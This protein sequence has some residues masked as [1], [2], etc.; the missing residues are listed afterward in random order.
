MHCS[1]HQVGLDQG[2]LSDARN[3][4]MSTSH[5]FLC[6]AGLQALAEHKDLLREASEQ[7]V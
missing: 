4:K 5:F 1:L 3:I 7:V 2:L 6:S